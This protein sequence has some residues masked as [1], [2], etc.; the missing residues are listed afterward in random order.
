MRGKETSWNMN[1]SSVSNKVQ[2]PHY[3][4]VCPPHTNTDTD[5][6]TYSGGQ[7][8]PCWHRAS[9]PDLVLGSFMRHMLDDLRDMI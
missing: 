9:S 4:F 5:P 8:A 6:N 1:Q 7:A 3:V 2:K